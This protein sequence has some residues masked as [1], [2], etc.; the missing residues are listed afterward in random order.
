M[1][2]C[3]SPFGL[4]V[5]SVREAL[6]LSVTGPTWPSYNGTY[7]YNG[8]F[9]G[10]P[11]FKKVDSNHFIYFGHFLGFPF[12]YIN[13]TDEAVPPAGPF[14]WNNTTAIAGIYGPEGGPSGDKTVVITV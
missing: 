5:P 13:T 4:I 1:A 8:E 12:W 14:W 2:E 6:T 9:N 7:Q 3:P 10:R 11:K